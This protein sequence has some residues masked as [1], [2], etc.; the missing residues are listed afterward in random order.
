MKNSMAGPLADTDST[1]KAVQKGEGQNFRLSDL[2]TNVSYKGK[3]SQSKDA[4]Q[5]HSKP[6]RTSIKADQ[7]RSR[8][9]D[10]LE[11]LDPESDSSS[12]EEPILSE[13]QAK[14]VLDADEDEDAASGN[15]NEDLD[16]LAAEGN[17]VKL[18]KLLAAEVRC[19]IAN[20]ARLTYMYGRRSKSHSCLRKG[21]RRCTNPLKLWMTLSGMH[22]C[23]LKP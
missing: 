4:L 15:N 3:S 14:Q 23:C 16:L 19:P 2:I 8:G 17:P 11:Q 6:K 1:K 5:P 12:D 20:G 22:M 9:D 18:K 21:R 13:D 7:R 10:H